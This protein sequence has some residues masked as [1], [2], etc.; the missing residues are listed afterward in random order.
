MTKYS[1]TDKKIEMATKDYFIHSHFFLND[2]NF[3]EETSFSEPIKGVLK[4]SDT[5]C[6]DCWIYPKNLNCA[7]IELEAPHH[8]LEGDIMT[9]LKKK[10]K[11]AKVYL[12]GKV[13]YLIDEKPIMDQGKVRVKADYANDF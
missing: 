1:L 3:S 13:K 5:E 6:V 4:I 10:G 11:N 8:I 2:C 7:V 9:I 12:T